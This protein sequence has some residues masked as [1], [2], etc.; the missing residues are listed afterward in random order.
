MGGASEPQMIQ[1][2]LLFGAFILWLL[3]PLIPALL[4]HKLLPDNAIKV[5]GPLQGL[6]VN[7]SGGIASYLLLVLLAGAFMQ[8]RLLPP[9][10]RLDD[11]GWQFEIP[12]VV[13]DAAG[14]PMLFESGARL[15][16]DVQEAPNPV[17]RRGGMVGY[18]ATLRATRMGGKLPTVSLVGHLPSGLKAEFRADR[19][20]AAGAAVAGRRQGGA[21]AA[22]A[23]QGHRGAAARTAPAV[24]SRSDAG[25]V[26]AVRRSLPA[27]AVAAAVGGWAAAGA[28]W[29]IQCPFDGEAVAGVAAQLGGTSSAERAT[30]P[31]PPPP[32]PSPA[33]RRPAAEDEAEPAAPAPPPPPPPQPGTCEVVGAS[34]MATARGAAL[35]CRATLMGRIRTQT[36][37]K[38][39]KVEVDGSTFSFVTRPA[40][41]ARNLDTVL[42]VTAPARKT[43]AATLMKVT[44]DNGRAGETTAPASTTSWSATEAQPGPWKAASSLLPQ[45]SRTKAP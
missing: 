42:K 44:F 32:P 25:G 21:R 13:Q 35:E 5:D 6:K 33:P 37:W 41:G 7:A 24:G 26:T 14:N 18:E 11:G 20:G 30:A 27:L 4:I 29:A 1:V 22:E 9:I 43:R 2:A 17:Y 15:S 36:P 23:A 34:V 8:Q 38:I 12:F 10:N 16:I 40:R 31:A 28:A 3:L 45:G 19:P 39:V